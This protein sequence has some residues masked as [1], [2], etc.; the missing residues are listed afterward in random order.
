[1][2]AERDDPCLRFKGES[3]C[4][5]NAT[6]GCSFQPNAEGCQSTDPSCQPGMCRGG[7]PLSDET[8]NAGEHE[9]GSPVG[10][11][12]DVGNRAMDE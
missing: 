12:S 9:A 2:K 1:M 11:G 4:R 6:L 3:E 7:D 8:V 5:A 10:G